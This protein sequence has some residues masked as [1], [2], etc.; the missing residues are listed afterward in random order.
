MSP[1]Y[2][3]YLVDKDDL[4]SIQKCKTVKELS[5][6]AEPRIGLHTPK[7]P[8]FAIG[9]RIYSFGENE[10]IPLRVQGQ[11][12]FVS[13]ELT[14]AYVGNFPAVYDKNDL[15][16]IIKN[17]QRKIVIELQSLIN[18]EQFFD[19]FIKSAHKQNEYFLRKLNNWQDYLANDLINTNAES[20]QITDSGEYEYAIFELVRLY[21]TID[22]ENNAC[23]RIASQG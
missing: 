10:E 19:D 14:A 11:D 16:E 15:L 18:N 1:R 9:T 4:K 6:W 23:V 17:Y 5:D 20:P 12:L 13:P 21:K 7:Q 8:I 2:H 3:L 22:W